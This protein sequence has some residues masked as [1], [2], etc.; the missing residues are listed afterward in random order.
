MGITCISDYG[1]D[2]DAATAGDCTVSNGDVTDNS[3]N[4][5]ARAVQ[6]EPIRSSH[7]KERDSPSNETE[8]STR[9]TK[10]TPLTGSFSTC[11]SRAHGQ[12]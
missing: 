7:Q 5:Y 11:R 9:I 1:Y 3:G 6:G 2:G 8:E 10:A 12:Q 4:S